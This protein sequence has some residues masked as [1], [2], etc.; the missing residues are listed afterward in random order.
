MKN[1]PYELVIAPPDYPGKRYRGRYCYEHHLVWWRHTE[2]VPG[3][4]ELIHHKDEHKRNNR[5]RNLEKLTRKEHDKHHSDKRHEA[6][7]ISVPCSR[8]RKEFR[9]LG[10]RYRH[11]VRN[12]ESGK[13][14]CSR[15]CQV[16]DQQADR[17]R[18]S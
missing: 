9:V 14:F 10:S 2:E 1:G 3:P 17:R 15:S 4:G 16:I 12:S 13:V 11:R 8:C 6:A 5:Y 18:N 7:L